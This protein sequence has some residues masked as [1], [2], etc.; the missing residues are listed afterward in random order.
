MFALETWIHSK[1]SILMFGYEIPTQ[2]LD[3]NP[4]H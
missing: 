2:Q 1:V 4:F 3:Q